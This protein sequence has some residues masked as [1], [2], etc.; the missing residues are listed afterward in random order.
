[1]SETSTAPIVERNIRALEMRRRRDAR[2]VG[3]HQ[4]LARRIA[5]LIGAMAFA[6]A[7]LAFFAGWVVVNQGWTPVTPFDPHLT[8]LTDVASI[9]AIFLSVFVLINQRLEVHAADQRADL[10]LQIGLLAEHEV[11][12][13]ITLTAAIAK[14]LGIEE[15]NDPELNALQKDTEPDAVL[16]RLAGKDEADKA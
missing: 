15:G 10:D 11:T 16:D 9:E 2:E 4:Q 8:L 6:Y 7:N 14:H 12:R 3:H 5:G 1:M 13:L